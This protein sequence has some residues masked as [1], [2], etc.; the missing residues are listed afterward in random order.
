M[1]RRKFSKL[2]RDNR[3]LISA[4]NEWESSPIRIFTEKGTTKKERP[5]DCKN[6]NRPAP[7][8]IPPHFKCP[9]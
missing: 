1:K 2:L 7:E 9:K 5:A 8:H 6:C 3:S 4:I